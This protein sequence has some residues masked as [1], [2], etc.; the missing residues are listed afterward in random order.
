MSPSTL[1]RLVRPE[2]FEL[3]TFSFEANCSSAE[4]RTYVSTI[5][6]SNLCSG[7]CNPI[8]SHSVNRAFCENR[9]N[10]TPDFWETT[11]RV[12]TTLC[13]R[14]RYK[15]LHPV[16]LVTNQAFYYLNYNDEF[17]IC[18]SIS[19]RRSKSLGFQAFNQP[20]L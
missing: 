11:R 12:T 4:L 6:G 19:L 20:L 13:S 3:P 17:L 8:P 16:P 15:E 10:R 2:R 5:Q 7:V 18:F 9:G 14:S 1:V